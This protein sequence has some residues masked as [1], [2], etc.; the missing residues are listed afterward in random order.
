MTTLSVLNH[1]DEC[2][3]C[4]EGMTIHSWGA[5]TPGMTNVEK[6]ISY[7][8]TCKPA[9]Q[10]WK[11]TKVLIIDESEDILSVNL[12]RTERGSQS[13]WWMDTYSI[14]LPPSR[15]DCG[16]RPTVPSVESRY[17]RVLNACIFSL[18]LLFAASSLSLEISFNYPLLRKAKTPISHLSVKHGPNASRT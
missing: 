15:I 4:L 18:H 1:P 14:L 5:I 9:H 12:P 11:A 10:R 8:K 13:Q 6:L 17:L 3:I 7:I 16:R 2:S